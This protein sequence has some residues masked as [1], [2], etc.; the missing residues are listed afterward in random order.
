MLEAT[1]APLWFKPNAG[2]PELEGGETVYRETP[3]EMAEKLAGLIEA[4][5]AI[6]GGCCGTTP[7][8]IERFAERVRALT[9]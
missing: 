2:L 1:D 4:G 9:S 7:T 3:E 8:H 6:V 5:A